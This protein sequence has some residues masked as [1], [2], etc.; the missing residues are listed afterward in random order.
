VASKAGTLVR[1]EHDGHSPN[2]NQGERHHGATTAPSIM[3]LAIRGNGP[4]STWFEAL[5]ARSITS[6]AR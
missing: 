1:G 4:P 3:P 6:L 5:K 2:R